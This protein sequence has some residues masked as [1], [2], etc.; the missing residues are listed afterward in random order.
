MLTR[1]RQGFTLVEVLI[2]IA[3]I[4]ILAG[5]VFPVFALTRE[6]ARSSSCLSNEKQLGAA[7]LLYVQDYDQR[8][9][10]GGITVDSYW[11]PYT[12]PGAGWAGGLYA[13]VKNPGVFH[14]PD[15]TTGL[16]QP[17]ATPISYLYNSNASG[18]GYGVN[19]TRINSPARSVLLAEVSG[20]VTDPRVPGETYAETGRQT[21]PSGQGVYLYAPDFNPARVQYET[22]YLG[23][24]NQN[25]A[26]FHNPGG[27]HSGGS[28][29]L[30]MDGHAR[31]LRPEQISPGSEWYTEPT[32]PGLC[33]AWGETPE[34]Y[35][36]GTESGRYAVTFSVQ[37]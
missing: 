27:R 4:A 3:I 36:A 29:I 9:L 13:Y 24:A 14:C 19:V 1:A 31:W 26:Q 10:H 37:N 6:R 5:I 23:G 16:S 32:F 18:W 2:V 30:L 8:T 28:N 34:C 7:F 11:G 20:I 35:A 21:S 15:D 22:G 33:W 17:G 12:V 25:P